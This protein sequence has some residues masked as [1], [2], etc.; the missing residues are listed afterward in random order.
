MSGF[1]ACGTPTVEHLVSIGIPRGK[2]TNFPYW[3]EIPNEWSVPK[4]CLDEAASRRP[5]RLLAIG[6][7][8]RVKQFEIAIQAV[9]V[10]NKKAGRDLVEL[11]LAGDGPERTNLEALAQ[12]LNCQSNVSF[13]GWLEPGEV[14]DELRQADA[15]VV[16]SSFEP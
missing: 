8:V 9:A 10:A 5:L 14:Y 3:V 11:V 15:L 12:S 2:I 6:R 1:L 16:T 4:R 13:P 7:H